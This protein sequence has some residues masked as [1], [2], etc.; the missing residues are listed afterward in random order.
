LKFQ[1]GI[2]VGSENYQEE[3]KP[4]IRV[5]NLS[6]HG[7]IERDQKY[8]SEDLYSQLKENY[9]PKLGD[10]LLTKDATPGIAYVV[11][12]PIKGIIASGIVRL[13]INEKEI[14]KEYLALCINSII[15][16][17]QIERDGVGSVI[18]HWKPSQI[19]NLL[20]PLLPNKWLTFFLI[21]FTSYFNSFLKFQNK[22]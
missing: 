6:I 8:I 4:F 18:T 14:D 13:S 17:L 9:E 3:G 10:F 19:K 11:K 16:R 12:K 20:I 1:K 21:I 15:G 5:S 22:I 7:L 2:E